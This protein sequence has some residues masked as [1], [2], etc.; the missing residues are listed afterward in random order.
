MKRLTAKQAAELAGVHPLTILNWVR[1]GV[2][3]DRRLLGARRHW[4]YESDF[5]KPTTL[6]KA[7]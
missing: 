4:F 5:S 2:I 6:D 3:P 7:A 1:R